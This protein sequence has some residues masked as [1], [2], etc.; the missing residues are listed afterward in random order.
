MKKKCTENKNRLI[1]Q[2]T[3]SRLKAPVC[4]RDEISPRVQSEE[5]VAR[6]KIDSNVG[7]TPKCLVAFK[8]DRTAGLAP[9]CH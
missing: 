1:A 8:T 7:G 5:T 6:Q 4:G 2:E 9:S 3:D